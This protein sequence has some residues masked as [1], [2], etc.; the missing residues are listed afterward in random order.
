M[1]KF[2]KKEKVS[3]DIKS[4]VAEV[5]KADEVKLEKYREKALAKGRKFK[6]PIQ[7]ANHKVVINAILISVLSLVALSILGFVGLYK[8]NDTGDILYRV[9]QVLPLPV[10]NVD[11]YGVR[12]SDYL[13]QYRSSIM[14]IEQL[15][16]KLEDTE[17]NQRRLNYYKQGAL[18]NAI[19]NGLALKLASEH[20]IIVSQEKI[21]EIFDEHRKSG[22]KELTEEQFLQTIRNNYGFSKSEYE[23]MFIELPLIRQEVQ[24]II[25]TR[26]SEAL[27]KLQME[28]E[29]RGFDETFNGINDIGF[30]TG[31]VISESSGGLVNSR[32]LDG[33]RATV[34]FSQAVETISKP[35]ISKAGDGY[36]IVKT[37]SKTNDGVEYVSFKIPF[38]ELTARLKLL[39]EEGK[40][41]EYVGPFDYSDQN[42]VK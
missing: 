4:T 2:H 37:L 21:D 27:K 26:A 10:A 25:D 7:Y 13:M 6:Y 12:F 19:A 33:G 24:V 22:E 42:M 40:I 23:R 14:A 32:N 9:T 39:R 31:S 5:V 15:E 11:G 29:D 41:K 17:D 28:I 1:I 36:Y 34:A 8:W 3:K 16:G 18:N 20:N 38:N 30:E 35:F